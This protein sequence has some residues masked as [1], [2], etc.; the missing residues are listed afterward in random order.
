MVYDMST[1][2]VLVTPPIKTPSQSA[3]QAAIQS[4]RSKDF[5]SIQ[6]AIISLFRSLGQL[7]LSIASSARTLAQSSLHEHVPA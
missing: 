3:H 4:Y 7:Y 5:T 1:S 2:T 6:A